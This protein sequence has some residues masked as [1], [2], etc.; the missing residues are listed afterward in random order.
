VIASGTP[1]SDAVAF[2]QWH[3]ARRLIE[4]GS[5]RLWEAAA[6]GLMDRVER[7]FASATPSPTRSRRRF[8]ARVTAP[9][10]ISR[11]S[12]AP[13]SRPEPDRL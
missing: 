10:R 12:P 13:R 7:Q 2:G 9:V 5:S 3:A 6:L 8:G 4:R 11:V 1:L